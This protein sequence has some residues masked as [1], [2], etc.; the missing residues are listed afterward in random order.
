MIH[1]KV[2]LSVL[3]NRE[4]AVPFSAYAAQLPFEPRSIRQWTKRIKC[5]CW[6]LKYRRKVCSLSRFSFKALLSSMYCSHLEDIR[7]EVSSQYGIG[8]GV[9]VLL[10]TSFSHYCDQTSKFEKLIKVVILMLDDRV[11]YVLDAYVRRL[12]PLT[13]FYSTVGK[14]WSWGSTR[15]SLGWVA[16]LSASGSFRE[17]LKEDQKA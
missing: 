16:C 13:E 8:K 10:K 14:R 2:V 7:C 9:R 15:L 6:S 4:E 12:T 3:I 1:T 11:A 5:R 17:T